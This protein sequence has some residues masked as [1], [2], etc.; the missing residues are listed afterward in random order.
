MRISSL[1][2]A[3]SVS[4]CAHAYSP[5]AHKAM[6]ESSVEDYNFCVET[7]NLSNRKI[8]DH[9]MGKI[10]F[11]NLRED[12]NPMVKLKHWHFYHPT[13]DLGK[14]MMG[15]GYGSFT[16]RYKEAEGKLKKRNPLKA[17]GTKSHYVQDV[18]NPAHVAPIYHGLGDGFD[19]YDFKAH[20]PEKITRSKC[21]EIYKN[22][23]AHKLAKSKVS[24]PLVKRVA[25]ATLEKMKEKVLV[26]SQTHHG[27][28]SW[29]EAFWSTSFGPTSKQANF[30]EYGFLGNTFGKPESAV[31][32]ATTAQFAKERVRAALDATV[33]L[34]LLEL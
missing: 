14:G 20:W 21:E 4:L 25:T 30:G 32:A 23:V 1:I 7:L 11:G 10:I 27:F 3:L 12:I 2:I 9:D 31:D 17:L 24:F 15:W 8:S 13:K 26:V 34:F 28:Y 6:V 19:F 16:E 5:G 22:V 33:E 18:T 29:E